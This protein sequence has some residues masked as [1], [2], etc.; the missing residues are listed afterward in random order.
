MDPLD[1]SLS[2]QT[3]LVL[4]DYAAVVAYLIFT[5]GIMIWFGRKQHSTEDFFVGSRHMPWFAVGLSILATLM[6]TNSY[7]AVPG[8]MV[9]FGIGFFTAYLAIPLSMLVIFYLWIPFFMR[10]RLTSAYEYLEK[11]FNYATRLLAAIL[12]ILLRLGW[13]SMV[14]Y[15]VSL[16]MGQMI[17]S[18]EAG[19]PGQELYW[20]IAGMGV[21]AAVYTALGGIQAMIWVDVL[22]FLLMLAGVVLTIGYVAYATGSGPLAWWDILTRVAPVHTQV[23]VFSLD[24][25]V[26]ITLVNALLYNFFW[27]ICTHG[28]DQV[29]LQRYFSTGSLAAARRSYLINV[30][31]EVTMLLL[32]LLSGLALLAFYLGHSGLLPEGESPVNSGDK[33]FPLFLTRQLPVGCAGLIIAGFLCDALQT[34]EAGVNSITAVINTDMIERNRKVPGGEPGLLR[35]R[36]LTIGLTSIVTLNAYWVAY[37]ASQ[38]GR[39]LISL[40][41]K[42]FNMY[43]GPLAA[44]FFT[45]MFLRRCSARSAI[46]AVLAG[47][48]VSFFYSYWEILFPGHKAPTFLLSV[49]APCVF[50]FA[51]AAFLGF[52]VERPLT[53]GESKLTWWAVVQQGQDADP[54]VKTVSAHLQ[55]S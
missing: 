36:L 24:L 50:T 53:D 31:A 39:T 29:V 12:F 32:L 40:M 25:T 46:P 34:L 1:T 2:P 30:C 44:L 43:V 21:L 14:L 19:K 10:L 3:R 15:G 22:Q 17:G 11:R 4:I 37:L 51:F 35:A 20:L 42:A 18:S 16:V 38:P 52:I 48:A 28:S 49:A 7:L 5:F 27:T 45:G 33:L 23:P 41:P 54:D 26:R 55:K 9:K 47:L 6:S 8:E 13:M